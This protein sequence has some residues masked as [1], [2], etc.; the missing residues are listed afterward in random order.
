[1]GNQLVLLGQHRGHSVAGG[2]SSCSGCSGGG[3][4][5][6]GR[7]SPPGSVP[8]TVLPLTDALAQLTHAFDPA[9][10]KACSSVIYHVSYVTKCN[11]TCVLNKSLQVAPSGY[12]QATCN[13]TGE[14]TEPMHVR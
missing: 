4:I 9:V 14:K 13:L 11:L 12:L 10:G 3:G 8:G 7:G 2:C 1:M 6:G 5:R